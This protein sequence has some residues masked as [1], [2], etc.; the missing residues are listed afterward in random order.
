MPMA[1][2]ERLEMKQPKMPQ[3]AKNARANFAL[4]R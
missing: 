3:F 4:M 2:H 1:S